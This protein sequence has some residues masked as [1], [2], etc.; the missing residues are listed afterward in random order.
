MS[1]GNS[2]GSVRAIGAVFIAFAVAFNI[3][4][5][6]LGMNF[7]YPGIL[8]Q[9][10]GVVLTRFAE[11]GTPV[12]L[13]WAS[14]ALAA[15]LFAPVAVAMARVTRRHGHPTAAVAAIGIAAGVVQAI[16]LSR[17][18]YAVPGLA[19]GWVAGDAGTRVMIETVFTTLHQSAGVGIGEAIG[20][21]LTGMWL[22]GVSLAQREHPRF[23]K[24]PAALG[25]LGGIVLLFGLDEGLATVI[26][27][28]PGVLRL[29]ALV[30]YIMLTL[31]L[32]WTGVLC[33]LRPRPTTA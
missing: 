32:I 1:D 25:G 7:G 8:R 14:F 4:Y 3:P 13:A 16:G 30:G 10:A 11:G 27:F 22:I 23:G 19:S 20:Q 2:Q 29:A 21:T 15:L 5:T 18:V 28:N 24:L 6:W 17:W 26:P 33:I 12:I 9:P 31:W